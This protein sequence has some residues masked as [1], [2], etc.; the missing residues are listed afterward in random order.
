M[1]NVEKDLYVE[2]ALP[3]VWKLEN[4]N[5]AFEEILRFSAEIPGL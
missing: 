1:Q 5:I 3:I 2:S 4:A